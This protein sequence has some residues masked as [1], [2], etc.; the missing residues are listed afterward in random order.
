VRC[1]KNA[2]ELYS[3]VELR[4]AGNLFTMKSPLKSLVSSALTP[5]KVKDDILNVTDRVKLVLRNLF[6]IDHCLLQ[7]YPYGLD[8]GAQLEFFSKW[9][10]KNE[11]KV[12][13]KVINYV[14]SVNSLVGFSSFKEVDLSLYLN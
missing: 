7:H 5:A 1:T 10:D 13:N 6:M 14:I 11:L 8:E 3:T 12:G 9:M 2:V 4:C